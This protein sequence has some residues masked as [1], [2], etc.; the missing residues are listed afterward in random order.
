MTVT[1]ST[2]VSKLGIAATM[3]LGAVIG[4]QIRKKQRESA[5]SVMDSSQ[6]HLFTD[7]SSNKNGET[8]GGTT[9]L[10]IHERLQ[11]MSL[12]RMPSSP[13]TSFHL[14]KAKKMC[15]QFLQANG[16]LKDN[17]ELWMSEWMER[18]DWVD[19]DEYWTKLPPPRP[20][21]Q[22]SYANTLLAGLMALWYLS[23]SKDFCKG[24]F[25]TDL[26]LMTTLKKVL[27]EKDSSATPIVLRIIAN[28]LA[29]TEDHQ[30]LY[31]TGLVDALTSSKEHSASDVFLPAWR[32]LLNLKPEKSKM[33]G[34]NII[35]EEGVY[36]YIMPDVMRSENAEID[37]ILVHGIQGGAELTWRQHDQERKKPLLTQ[38]QRQSLL[39]GQFAADIDNF[40]T[41]C[42]PLDWLVP[43][44]DVPVRVLAVDYEANWWHWGSSC[45]EEALGTVAS[46]SRKIVNSLEAAG[47][48]ERPIVW[49]THSMG[50]LIVKDML[51]NDM[52]LQCNSPTKL[53]KQSESLAGPSV[54]GARKN[55][56]S[57]TLGVIF[58]S[59]PHY[60]SP[61]ASSVTRGILRH[62]LKPSSEVFDMR[63]ES[64]ILDELHQSF[65][66]M[67]EA[68]G[69]AVLTLNESNPVRHRATGLDL[70]FVPPKYG[71]SGVGEFY[72]AD[73]CHVDICKPLNRTQKQSKP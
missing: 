26:T 34:K 61:L 58:F 52:D 33:T 48:G 72:E 16:F 19:G 2:A 44:I 46:H 42:W 5:P 1:L 59:V 69:I 50:G 45:A 14:E 17:S 32:G 38:K 43:S 65:L 57:Q 20:S 49:M 23:C 25:T 62:I 53:E 37:I 47:V 63:E 31:Q 39:L 3:I 18:T 30:P 40:Y 9:I 60:G 27:D 4:N 29:V 11:D 6:R 68:Q 35:Y 8:K 56:S 55:L 13:T 71:T 21:A 12:N 15:Q 10:D 24:N 41:S 7:K 64:P 54:F 67:V 22:P 28:I 66:R 36:P 73:A 70:L 51:M